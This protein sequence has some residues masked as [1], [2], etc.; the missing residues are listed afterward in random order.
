M[1]EQSNITPHMLRHTFCPR[2]ANADMN[3]KALQYIMG[4]KDISTTLNL[5]THA[6]L[7][8]V[9]IEVERLI[10]YKRVDLLPIYSSKVVR[11]NIVRT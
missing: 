4:H 1:G 7:G 2:L 3:S 8:T 11:T 10:L 5:Y 9:K 6:T